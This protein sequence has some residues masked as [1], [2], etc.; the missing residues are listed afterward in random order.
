[1]R[2]TACRFCKNNIKNMKNKTMREALIYA[3]D[4]KISEGIEHI[5]TLE[6]AITALETVKHRK[7]VDAHGITAIK[8][9]GGS[10]SLSNDYTPRL[11]LYCEKRIYDTSAPDAHGCS[12]SNYYESTDEVVY[13]EHNEGY[14]GI[15]EGAKRR[16]QAITEYSAQLEKEKQNADTIIDEYIALEKAKSA[17]DDYSRITREAIKGY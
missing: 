8:N 16:I 11:T 7:N 2:R 15:I 14:A 12:I 13:F 4:K 5:K 10:A 1:M 6:Q 9:G 17:Y 3:C